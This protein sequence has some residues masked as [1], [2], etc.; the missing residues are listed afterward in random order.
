M[1]QILRCL[2]F[3]REMSRCNYDRISFELYTCVISSSSFH[4]AFSLNITVKN[5]QFIIIHCVFNYIPQRKGKKW[6]RWIFHCT[7]SQGIAWDENYQCITSLA[8]DKLSTFI[9]FTGAI[10]PLAIKDCNVHR[11]LSKIRD[12]ARTK[13]ANCF[14]LCYLSSPSLGTMST[15]VLL[16]RLTF[17]YVIST[18]LKMCRPKYTLEWRSK[19]GKSNNDGTFFIKNSILR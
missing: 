19:M 10:K 17:W 5:V 4:K 13:A 8:E 16:R 18:S 2:K 12:T 11:S 15:W 7:S 1:A 14:I 6:T 9:I 3:A